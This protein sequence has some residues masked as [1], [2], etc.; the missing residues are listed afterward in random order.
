MALGQFDVQCPCG[1]KTGNIQINFKCI[2][3][4]NIKWK[5][6]KL[7]YDGKEYLHDIS[8]GKNY[9]SK[10]QKSTMQKNKTRTFTLNYNFHHQKTSQ[11]EGIWI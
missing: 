1:K 8:V 5:A 3:D 4:L 7:L 9:P 10:S 11:K 2:K 6:I